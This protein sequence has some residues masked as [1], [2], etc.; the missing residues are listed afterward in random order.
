MSSLLTGVERAGIGPLQ[1]TDGVTCVPCDENAAPIITP[2]S[3]T[4]EVFANY[5]RK[6][7]AHVA[8]LRKLKEARE[9]TQAEQPHG[10]T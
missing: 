2:F 1:H 8:R 3:S 9:S 10:P 7:D 5:D 6:A 4:A